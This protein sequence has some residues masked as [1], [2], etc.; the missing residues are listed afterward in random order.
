MGVQITFDYAIWIARYPEFDT[1]TETTALM[2]FAEASVHHRN[3][4]GGP[5]EDA[6]VQLVLLNMMTAHV[7]ALYGSVNGQA[8]S[9]LVG[10]INS[11]SEG[12]VSVGVEGFAGVS[13]ERQWLLQTKYGASYWYATASYRLMRYRVPPPRVF[14]PGLPS[15]FLVRRRT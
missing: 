7:A 3:D 2:Y 4:G 8:P 9:P 5:V 6:T 14:G 15:P 12:S 11:A 10:R 13:G 1:V